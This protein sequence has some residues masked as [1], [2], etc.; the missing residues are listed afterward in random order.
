MYRQT[1]HEVTPA[2]FERYPTAEEMSK[3]EP[4]DLFEYIRSVSYPNAKSRHLSEMSRMIVD[5]FGG[6]VPDDP[7]DLVKLPGVDGR[8]PTCCRLYGLVGR[9][10]C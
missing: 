9:H 10:G 1:H 5:D 4:E 2:L 3:A 6:E 8:R 7:K